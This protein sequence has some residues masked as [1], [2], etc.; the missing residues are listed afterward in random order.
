[1]NAKA[2][3]AV[4]ATNTFFLF[5]GLACLLLYGLFPMMGEMVARRFE[6][7]G[8]EPVSDWTATQPA[9]SGRVNNIRAN[10]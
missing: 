8:H 2:G 1:M 10:L 9:P 6:G 4:F 7:F 5:V 3:V